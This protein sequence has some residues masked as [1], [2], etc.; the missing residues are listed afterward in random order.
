MSERNEY[1]PGVP[2][3]VDTLQSD[4]DG[5]MRFYGDVFGW[6]F[7]GPGTMPGDPPGRYYVAQLRGRDVAG[8]GTMPND[9]SSS[10]PVWNTYISVQ[11]ADE[12]AQDVVRAGGGIVME[13]F[14]ALPAGRMGVFADSTGA[15]F[16]AWEP[17]DRQGAQLVN[18][19][20][21]WA[22]SMLLARDLEASMKFYEEVFDWKSE[23]M[24][25]GENE[26][27]LLRLPGYFGGE[28]EQ[29]VPRDLV[30]VLA[31]LSKDIPDHVPPHWQAGFWIDDVDK[32]AAMARQLG[33][34]IIVP[35]HDAAGFRQ[36][37]LADP[38]GAVFSVSKVSTNLSA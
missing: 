15:S 7:V 35:P 30:A 13:P 37:I 28:P 12:T 16:C 3:W 4:P 34:K 14:D 38:Q 22:M 26:I 9:G 29:P 1:P 10:S 6:N 5:A 17:K 36:S 32:A 2:C 27:T 24:K 25:F 18:E 11:S 8:I 31:L 33:G 21:A 19:P 20:G 23:T